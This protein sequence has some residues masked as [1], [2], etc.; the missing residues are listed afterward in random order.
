[1]V[2]LSM[3]FRPNAIHY[4]AAVASETKDCFLKISRDH[5]LSQLTDVNRGNTVNVQCVALKEIFEIHGISH[6]NFMSVDVEGFELEAL[7]GIDWNK[8]TF[9]VICIEK[10]NR[11]EITSFMT[12]RDMHHFQNVA[13]DVIF[14]SQAFINQLRG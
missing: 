11:P 6:V 10:G 12:E 7:K 14:A 5:F 13:G 2:N 8:V 1:M 3:Q 9:D 4:N